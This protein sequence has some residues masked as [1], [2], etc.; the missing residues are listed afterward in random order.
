M[1]ARVERRNDH[2]PARPDA[3]TEAPGA[4]IVETAEPRDLHAI[5]REAVQL[6]IWRRAIAPDLRLW[7]DSLDLRGLGELRFL[8]HPS[9]IEACFLPGLEQAG[10]RP[11]GM[12]ER[13]VADI[14]ALAT[15]YAE[16]T[17][18]RLVDVRLEH[19]T[20]DA[21]WK[22]HRDHVHTR[23]LTTYR[24]LGTQWVPPSHAVEAVRRQK[25]YRGPLEHLPEGAVALFKGDCCG[26]DAGIV[27][28]SPPIARTGWSRLLLCLSPPSPASPERRT[29]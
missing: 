4:D 11:Q 26:D 15:G 20:H 21:C 14:R 8:I 23:L 6:V 9:E 28:R 2:R 25:A 17:D 12:V 7:L 13:L 22:F 16:A 1:Y 27:H 18:N 10:F 3:R 29:G 5:R 24:G 19:V